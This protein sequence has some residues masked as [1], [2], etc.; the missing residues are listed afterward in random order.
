MGFRLCVYAFNATCWDGL[1]FQALGGKAFSADHLFISPSMEFC[2]Q[3]LL[4]NHGCF[5]SVR[6]TKI[7]F[8]MMHQ[9]QQVSAV[10]GIARQRGQKLWSIECFDLGAT[11][12]C[13]QLK[14]VFNYHTQIYNHPCYCFCL[15]HLKMGP[16]NFDP[17]SIIWTPLLDDKW[18]HLVFTQIVLSAFV[19]L[20]ISPL[21]L[22]EKLIQIFS[23]W[24]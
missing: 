7:C 6:A 14:S 19:K 13:R 9:L 18:S 2:E 16:Y 17:K 20:N 1:L 5:M 21:L 10:L 12:E 15:P 23:L 24:I 11:K 22:Q 4:V 8:E 3:V